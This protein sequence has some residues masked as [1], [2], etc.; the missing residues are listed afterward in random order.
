MNNFQRRSNNNYQSLQIKKSGFSNTSNNIFSKMA[1]N[2]RS[3]SPPKQ[4]GALKQY[5]N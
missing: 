3:N 1:Q 4:K 5:L 2:R